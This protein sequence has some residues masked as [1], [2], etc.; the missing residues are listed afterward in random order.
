MASD[1]DVIYQSNMYAIIQSWLRKEVIRKKVTQIGVAVF[2]DAKY[3]TK[4]SVTDM[5]KRAWLIEKPDPLVQESCTMATTCSECLITRVLAKMDT[6]KNT[7]LYMKNIL[8][9]FSIRMKSFIIS[10]ILKQTIVS[11][12]LCLLTQAG[13]LST[14]ILALREL[15]NRRKESAIRTRVT[16]I[17]KAKN[18]HA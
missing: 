11:R 17:G 6:L 16:L 12:I 14:T 15:M 9:D 7:G 1:V 4:N 18:I 3:A 10:T 2:Q 5:Q 8:E 13:T